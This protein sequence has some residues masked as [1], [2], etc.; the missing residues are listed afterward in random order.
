LQKSEVLENALLWGFERKAEKM[1]WCWG[2]VIAAGKR[3][4]Y[5]LFEEANAPGV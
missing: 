5:G 4:R 2:W 3:D 1:G